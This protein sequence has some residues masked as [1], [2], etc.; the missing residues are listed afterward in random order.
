[1]LLKS[2]HLIVLLPRRRNIHEVENLADFD[3]LQTKW[4][5]FDRK[6]YWQFEKSNKLTIS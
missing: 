2:K 5:F 4:Q 3:S 1:M 6:R